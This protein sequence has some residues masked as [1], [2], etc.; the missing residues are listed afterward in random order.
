[1]KYFIVIILFIICSTSFALENKKSFKTTETHTWVSDGLTLI[2]V[3]ADNVITQKILAGN[4]DGGMAS[5]KIKQAYEKLKAATSIWSI[6]DIQNQLGP[7]YSITR[8]KSEVI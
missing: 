7:E 8:N 5:K 2:V 3:I 6:K 4:N 1:M